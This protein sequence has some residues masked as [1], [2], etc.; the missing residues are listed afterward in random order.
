MIR[1]NLL[2]D[3]ILSTDIRLIR[4]VIHN[5]IRFNPPVQKLPS[6]HT[7]LNI[8]PADEIFSLSGF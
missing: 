3:E 1:E 4:Q 8:L 2:Y 7:A 5:F 6:I